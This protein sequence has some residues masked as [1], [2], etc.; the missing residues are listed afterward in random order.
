[1]AGLALPKLRWLLAGGLAAGV[2]VVSQEKH[3]P[4]PPERVP[5]VKAFASPARQA[6]PPAGLGVVLPKRVDRPPPR[7][8]NIVTGS[9]RKPD[10]PRLLRTTAA[11]NVRA[12]SELGS[13][14][15]VT[16]EDG[17]IVRELAR[18]GAWRLV[19]AGRTRGW[20]HSRYLGP[21][22]RSPRR[23]SLPVPGEPARPAAPSP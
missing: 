2:W 8:E 22:V 16:L 4:R 5:V 3:V 20:V 19:T 10:R 12:R 23:P 13:P 18:S 1:M 6:R 7:P 21:P 15:I 14:V 11:V 17:R 9:V